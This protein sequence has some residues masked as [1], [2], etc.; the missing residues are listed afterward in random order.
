MLLALHKM[1]LSLHNVT[2]P[3]SVPAQLPLPFSL[4]DTPLDWAHPDLHV[5][6]PPCPNGVSL[7]NSRINTLYFFFK[8][9]FPV[10]NYAYMSEWKC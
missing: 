5:A 4:I 8:A 2:V 3:Y 9:R 10:Y 6:W 1:L 7:L